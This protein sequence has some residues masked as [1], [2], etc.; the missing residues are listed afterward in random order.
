MKKHSFPPPEQ[1]A[2]VVPATVDWYGMRP[3]SF[4]SLTIAGLA[5]VLTSWTKLCWMACAVFGAIN[6]KNNATMA[7]DPRL[8]KIRFENFIASFLFWVSLFLSLLMSAA[9]RGWLT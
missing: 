3:G 4:I 2:G 1:L 9:I 7:T 8:I 5:V 6:I